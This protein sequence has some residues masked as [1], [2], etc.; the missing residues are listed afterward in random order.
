MS[1]EL[2]RDCEQ[3]I[4]IWKR[5]AHLVKSKEKCT[6][7]EAPKVVI[8]FFIQNLSKE[9]ALVRLQLTGRPNRVLYSQKPKMN[10][11]HIDPSK[12][13]Y[14]CKGPFTSVFDVTCMH[15]QDTPNLKST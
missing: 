1:S 14:I 9:V 12:E 3:F 13:F 11:F 10:I 4:E 6:K 5:N 7:I 2:F 15:S 8:F